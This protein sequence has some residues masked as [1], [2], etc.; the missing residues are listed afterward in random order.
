M[1]RIVIGVH[2]L[3]KKP[4]RELYHKWWRK[5]FYEGLS[6]IGHPRRLVPF[7]TCYWADIL[8]ALPQLPWITNRNDERYLDEPYVPGTDH[9]GATTLAHAQGTDEPVRQTNGSS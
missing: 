1:Q 9:T 8:H 5:S 4:S 3:G 7:V 6:R 2:G